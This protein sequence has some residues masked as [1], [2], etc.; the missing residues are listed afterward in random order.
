VRPAGHSA[1]TSLLGGAP[2]ATLDVA[3][4]GRVQGYVPVVSLAPMQS[5]AF[6]LR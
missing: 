2:A 5:Y 6:Q 4:D 3:A 1:A